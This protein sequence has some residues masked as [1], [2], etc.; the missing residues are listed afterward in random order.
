MNHSGQTPRRI[1]LTGASSGIGLAA[2][3]SLT[4]A[5]CQVWGTARSLERLPAD[6]P[7]FHPVVL[8]LAEELSI[9]EGFLSA[10]AAAGGR[11]DVLINNAGG[12]WF[13][14]VAQIPAAELRHQFQTLV[15]GPMQLIQLALPAMRAAQP[16]PKGLIIN[17]TSLSAR[18]PLPY[19]AAYSAAKAALSSFSATL[20][21][22]E[23]D[24][25]RGAIH[26]VDLQPGDIATNFNRAMTRTPELGTSAT[27]GSQPHPPD[28]AA[29]AAARRVL[30]VSDRDMSTAPPPELVA[31][32]IRRLV[33]A[34][35][36]PAVRACGMFF[37]AKLGVLASRILPSQLLE[38]SIR[39]HFK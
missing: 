10:Q 27:A 1:F 17:V 38:R 29:L 15:F 7:G 26:F 25:S 30:A 6:L 4:A 23:A 11:F 21:M 18:L 5:G 34:R 36:H 32:E 19:A 22:E 33:F 3:R 12:G 16:K 9:Q 8:D 37:Q 39:G 14:P 35:S 31:K 24:V 13:G 2:A 20:R 28:G